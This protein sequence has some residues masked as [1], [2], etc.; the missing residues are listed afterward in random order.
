M[1]QKAVRSL[2]DVLG[3]NNFSSTS[4]CSQRHVGFVFDD[5]R[6]SGALAFGISGNVPIAHYSL[7]SFLLRWVEED[8]D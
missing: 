7:P 6:H 1:S 8:S 3:T 5:D 2:R 4:M